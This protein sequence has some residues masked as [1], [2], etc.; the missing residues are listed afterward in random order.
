MWNWSS[1]YPVSEIGLV[2]WNA[3]LAVKPEIRVGS[4]GQSVRSIGEG[5]VCIAVNS[6]A[7][8]V[9]VG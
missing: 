3:E 5:E 1:K 7:S 9:K 4:K 6:A 8:S 2:T